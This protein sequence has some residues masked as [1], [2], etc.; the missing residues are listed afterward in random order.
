MRAV[1][2]I[3][4]SCAFV[5]DFVIFVTIFS[6]LQSL[7]NAVYPGN[8]VPP[9]GMQLF[10]AREFQIFF[11]TLASALV[12]LGLY[13]KMSYAVF[14]GQTFGHKIFGIQIVD[15]KGNRLS[16]GRQ[17]LVLLLAALRFI[18]FFIPGPVVALKG[19]SLA[20]SVFVLL[21]GTLLI[22]PIPYKSRQERVTI[23]QH[24]GGYRFKNIKG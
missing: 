14:S 16:S 19:G 18:I 6:V 24:L 8:Y 4:R 12:L 1:L 5:I 17:N 11:V 22:L 10:T 21:W 23:W 3:K 13:L 20:F 7:V 2:Q 9:K 15:L